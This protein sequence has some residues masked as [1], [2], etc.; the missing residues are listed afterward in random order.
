MNVIHALVGAI[1]AKFWPKKTAI[2]ALRGNLKSAGVNVHA[3]PSKVYEDIAVEEVEIARSLARHKGLVAFASELNKWI[4]IDAQ[5]IVNCINLSHSDETMEALKKSP[6]YWML[7]KN[8]VIN[9]VQSI[10]DCAAIN[11]VLQNLTKN[12]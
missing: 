4:E 5:I 1:G 7:V 11:Q 8:N 12:F 6:I 3:I 9:D 10:E 2:H